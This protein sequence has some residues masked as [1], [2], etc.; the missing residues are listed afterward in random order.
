[1]ETAHLKPILKSLI[2][3]TTERLG[4]TDP[5]PAVGA[6]ALNV[7]GEILSQKFHEGA[8]TPHAEAMVIADL[9]ARGILDQAKILLVT[10]EPCNHTGRTPPCTHAILES[11]IKSVFYGV[12]DP[13]PRV[14]GGGGKFLR[15]HG[16]TCELFPDSEIETESKHLIRAFAHWSKTGKPWVTVKQAFDTK[17]SMIPPEGKKTFTSPSSL[18][19]AHR[20]R[21]RAGAIL[22]GSGTIL[23]DLPEFTVRHVTDHFVNNSEPA[24]KLSREIAI[25]DRRGRVKSQ[26]KDWI[27]SAE[28]KGFQVAFYSTPAEA[29]S[30]LGA[31]GVLEILV[32]AGPTL[33]NAIIELGIANERV[34]ITQ[35][36]SGGKNTDKVETEICSPGL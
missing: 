27:L 5:N 14:A 2:A 33:S 8:G 18:E 36:G 12:S 23:A 35:N 10:L 30:V 15:D 28:S 21:K 34:T 29:L 26:A 24:R 11:G 4:S 7:R 20:L 22:T 31:R 25:L 6:T 1:M 19:L 9:R 17:G 13:N 16:V 3:L 32:E